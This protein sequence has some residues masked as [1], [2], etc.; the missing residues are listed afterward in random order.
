MAQNNQ[1]FRQTDLIT[2]DALFQNPVVRPLGRILAPMILGLTGARRINWVYRQIQA[3]P[4][5]LGFF[6]KCL[7]VFEI[8][9]EVARRDR[10]RLPT[11][12]PLVV[13]A[14]HPFGGLD[15]IILGALMNRLRSDVKILGNHLLGRI[16]EIKSQVIAVDV[17][18]PQNAVV[19]NSRAMMTAV[20][21]VR[22]GGCLLAF[23]AGEVSRFSWRTRR[24]EDQRWSRH[25]GSII[26][27][28]K[29]TVV[30]VYFHGRNSVLFQVASLF[31]PL[32][33]TALL[34]REM[35]SQ[36]GRRPRVLIGKPRPGSKLPH[37]QNDDDMVDYL[38]RQTYFLANRMGRR[39]ILPLPPQ[40]KVRKRPEN[41]IPAVAT[42]A[43]E[44]EIAALPPEQE[45]TRHGAFSVFEARAAQIP[46]LLKEIGR[47]R[48]T[49]FREA[50]EGTGRALDLDLFDDYY[51]HLFLWHRDNREIAGAYRL[52]LTDRIMAAYGPQGLYTSTLFRFKSQILKELGDAIELGRSFIPKA[53][54][55]HP[56]CLFLLWRGIGNF[57]LNNL[58]YC[59]LFGPVSISRD[60]Q[61]ISR[62]LMVHF[63]RRNKMD[64]ELAQF[65]SP[66]RPVR[67][68]TIHGLRPEDLHF[69]GTDIESI[70]I[71]IS[72]LEEDGKGLPVLLKHYLKLEATLLSFN[73]D[74]DFSD[75]IDGLIIL[76]LTRTDARMVERVMGPEGYRRFRARHD[77]HPPHPDYRRAG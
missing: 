28:S 50:G 8:E 70:S 53:Y 32:L 19:E 35:A 51:R 62:E 7:K 56:A 74:K 63:L 61:R 9:P 34:P 76:D 20:R 36:T 46:N 73:L 4:A 14:N 21:W 67:L 43:L 40:I 77:R 2:L 75:V 15:G 10:K 59:R 54:Q 68:Q 5:D 23:P 13:V 71:L 22:R 41:I 69:G 18:D 49:T 52:G 42:E 47:L 64:H 6:E 27:L 39:R 58:G 16:P 55:R 60:Y 25:V 37:Q 1:S 29:A 11:D 45:L 72:E 65:V 48:E 30:P 26:R 38:R 57:I 33:G 66:R 31:H 3:M 24:V 12:G 17:F 44:A